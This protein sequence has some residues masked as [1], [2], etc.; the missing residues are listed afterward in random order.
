MRNIIVFGASVLISL[1]S[2]AQ[3]DQEVVYFT[4]LEEKPKDLSVLS[5]ELPIWH[6]TGSQ[7]NFSLYDLKTS[8]TYLGG[9][10]IN[11]GATFN[12]KIGDRILPDTYE[13]LEYVNNNMVMS[14]NES[15]RA[16]SLNV[17]GTYFFKE[18]LEPVTETIRLKKVGNTIYVTNV[19]TKAFKRM[20]FNLG[21][22]QGYTWYNLNNMS[23][24][25]AREET[26]TAIE[27]VSENSQST[28]QDYKHIKAG[29]TFTK[30]VNMKVNVKDYGVRKSNHITMNSF[31]VIYA[32]QNDFDD[33]YWGRYNTYTNEVEYLPY[34]FT[35]DNKKLPIGFEYTHKSMDSGWFSYEYGVGYYPGL[36]KKIN[37]GVHF[38][39]SVSFNFMKKRAL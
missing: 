39:V 24:S 33:V 27:T 22:T 6:L 17:W 32:I 10:K 4:E 36:L 14:Q 31:N 23:I 11:G 34:L 7:V 9:S 3:K 29:I 19:D 5:L 2:F 15:V 26:P 28:M 38:G 13:G 18:S 30:A 8:L 21:Y 25:V 37:I 1:S 35:D 12:W 20:G 16:Q